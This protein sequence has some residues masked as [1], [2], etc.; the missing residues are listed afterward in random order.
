M[1]LRCQSEPRRE[2]A[3]VLEVSNLAAGRCDHGSRSEASMDVDGRLQTSMDGSGPDSKSERKCR[4]NL[5]FRVRVEV[6]CP[7]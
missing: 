2:V 6:C 7:H 5:V 4:T 3:C 1:F